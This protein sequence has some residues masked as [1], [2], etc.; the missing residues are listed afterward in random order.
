[1]RPPQWV[2]AGLGAAG[3]RPIRR[4]ER[5]PRATTTLDDLHRASPWLW[6]NCERCQDHAPLACAVAVIRWGAGTSSDVVRQRALHAVR[7]QG[8]NGAAP[9]AGRC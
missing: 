4:D 5:I 3:R 7:T 2:A 9:R 8:R 6:L 1:M